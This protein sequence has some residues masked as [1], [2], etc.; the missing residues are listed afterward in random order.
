[1]SYSPRDKVV[2]KSRRVVRGYAAA[3]SDWNPGSS[4]SAL[5]RQMQREYEGRFLYELVQNAYDAHPVDARGDIVVLLD[6]GEGDHGVLYV[7]NGGSPFTE[8]NFEAICDLARSDKAPDVSIGNKGVGFKSV[9]Q[10]C[11]WPEIYSAAKLGQDSFEG[12]CFTF[13]R[14]EMY[15][16]LAG[17]DTGLATQMRADLSPYFLPTPIDHQPP[18]VL[19]FASRGFATVIR[20][21]IKSPSAREIAVERVTRLA[22]ED[23]PVHLFLERLRTLEITR[24]DR[25]SGAQTRRLSREAT[26]LGDPAPDSGQR[27]EYVNLGE[28]GQWFITSRCMPAEAMREA[29]AESIAEG[30]L[31]ESW[32][33]WSRDAW[34][35]VAT[36]TDGLEIRP[37]LYTFLPMEREA[38]APLH[39]HI[40][41]PF[42]TMLARTSVSENV[43]LNARLLDCAA[44][45]S[46][47]AV[48]A[49][50]DNDDVLPESAL[51][52]LLAWDGDH[53]RRVTQSFADAGVEMKDLEVIPI[54]PL[55]G[56]RRA[57]LSS[58]YTWQYADLAL[59][60]QRCL[61]RDAGAEL[62]STGITGGRLK[63]LEAYCRAFF[64]V[65]FQAE[66]NLRAGWVEMVA[67]AL[68]ARR[69]RPRAWENFYADLAKIFEHDAT[70]LRGRTILLGDDGQLHSSPPDDD[71]ADHPLV[72]FPPA[73]E[74]T[75]EDDEVDADVDLKPPAT[76]RRALVLM[77]EE[78]RWTRQDG[79][80]RRR[81]PARRFLEDSKLVRRFRTV[82]LLEH[83]G[84]ALARS[85][86]ADLARDALRFTF[87]LSIA[88]RSV[89]QRDLHA[90]GLRVPTRGGWQRADQ[91]FFSPGWGTPLA[92]PLSELIDRASSSSE[93]A[94]TADLLLNEPGDWPCPADDRAGWRAF[95][96]QIGVRDGL[97]PQPVAHGRDFWNGS[98]LTPRRVARRFNLTEADTERWVQAV[99]ARTG[100]EPAHPLTPYR[101]RDDISLI[102]GQAEYEV[103]DHRARVLFGYLVTAGLEHWPT[104][105]LEISWHRYR[106]PAQPDERRWP[107]PIAAF[108]RET[109]WL[110]VTGSGQRREESFAAPCDAWYFADSRGEELPY[111]SP[112]LTG[113]LRRRLSPDGKALARLKQ[114]GLA[115][116][117]DPDDAPRLLRHLASLVDQDALAETGVFAFRRAYEEAWSRAA[118]LPLERFVADAGDLPVV[119]TRAGQLTTRRPS[120]TAEPHLFLLGQDSSLAS[121]AL[122]AS[123][124]PVIDINSK[125]EARVRPLLKTL[126]QDHLLTVDD[127]KFEVITDTGKFTPDGSG[128]LLVDGDRR[129]LETVNIQ[130]PGLDV[131]LSD[132]RLRSGG[133]FVRVMCVPSR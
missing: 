114:A 79:P 108:L 87:S 19:E 8:E 52:D 74:R 4:L 48:L 80:A 76:L 88:T 24:L 5:L 33:A 113:S 102:P 13:A 64:Q 81:T 72:F 30:Q 92:A 100:W 101:P 56:R 68:H 91:A 38:S 67:K 29:I 89:R 99:T 18:R 112:L 12:Y 36:R 129:W 58:T 96:M 15:L 47:A 10:V 7:A 41:A 42:S 59:L 27:Y 11:Q 82:D 125:D 70:A 73:R 53:H 54:E 111:F 105:A 9:L 25:E 1:M 95:L 97:W 32:A 20:L 39:G 123:D 90:I 103:F 77:S 109:A 2:E 104:G 117:N 17:G 65:G 23:V 69:S 107:S 94:A 37:R 119:V 46:T 45:A 110:P 44:R 34:V 124:L 128:D 83:I 126:F 50:R 106:H 3:R 14:P 6:L 127:L 61:A 132:D 63:R 16:E 22:E 115:D 86:R 40:H 131:P 84:R 26:P 133:D 93:I 60:N 51:V 57:A 98:Y 116:W 121:R 55:A 62:V 122:E 35:S 120:D 66:A 21:P 71:S 75:D 130:V 118:G 49:F 31:E 43:I 78:L 85:N 28:Q